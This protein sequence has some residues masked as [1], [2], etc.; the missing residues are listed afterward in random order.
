MIAFEEF[1]I[2][3]NYVSESMGEAPHSSIENPLKY[4]QRPVPIC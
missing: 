2:K 4:A 3:R 1:E